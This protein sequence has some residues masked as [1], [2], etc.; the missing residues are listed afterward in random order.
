M[1]GAEEERKNQTELQEERFARPTENTLK[2]RA[3][4]DA[5]GADGLP[6]R[7]KK[8]QEGDVII[9]KV[10]P[11]RSTADGIPRTRDASYVVPVGE[12]GVIDDV[13]CSIN[14]DG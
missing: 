13:S 8:V 14:G 10:I 4:Y 11:T 3:N 7:G 2:S 12:S 1:L 5:I 9:G 6:I